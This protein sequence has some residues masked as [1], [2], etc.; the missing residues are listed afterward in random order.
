VRTLIGL[1]LT[2]AGGGLL[3][4]GNEKHK[5]VGE[6]IGRFFGA[7]SS[8]EVKLFLVGGVVCVLL[9]LGT[10]GM[11]KLTKGKQK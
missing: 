9:G 4:A 10:L 8:D 3:Y 5:E 2:L 7:G 6:S 1:V 11:D